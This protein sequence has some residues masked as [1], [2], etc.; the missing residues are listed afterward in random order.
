MVIT[1]HNSPFLPVILVTVSRGI[2]LDY[3]TMYLIKKWNS[4][5]QSK[6]ADL[7]GIAQVVSVMLFYLVVVYAVFYFL[8]EWGSTPERFSNGK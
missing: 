8:G 3:T 5:P 1:T 4:I 2:M 6:R 7:V